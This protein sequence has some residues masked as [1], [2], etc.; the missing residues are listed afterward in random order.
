MEIICKTGDET[1][2]IGY[3]LGKHAISGDVFC[4]SGDLGAGKTLLCRGVARAQGVSAVD[5]TS[6][7][8]TLTKESDTDS[9][10]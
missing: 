2:K 7:T 10:L 3:V 6:P 9:I 4:L 8:F 1:E 5:V